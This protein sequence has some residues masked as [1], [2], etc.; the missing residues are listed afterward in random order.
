MALHDENERMKDNLDYIVKGGDPKKLEQK[1]VDGLFHE[2]DNSSQ[3][4]TPQIDNAFDQYS[5][6]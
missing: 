2:A 6:F 1:M 3:F 5:D 4:K